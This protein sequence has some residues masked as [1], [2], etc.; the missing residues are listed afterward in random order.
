[1]SVELSTVINPELFKSATDGL[2]GEGSLK[3]NGSTLSWT[4]DPLRAYVGLLSTGTASLSLVADVAQD[5]TSATMWSQTASKNTTVDLVAGQVTINV[6][7]VYALNSWVT[8]SS[9]TLNTL[10]SIKYNV[11]GV[12]SPSSLKG[13]SKDVGDTNNLSATGLV[14][15]N[16][17]DTVKITIESDKNCTATISDCGYSMIKVDEV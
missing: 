5:I 9:D 12:P 15:F 3:Y 8:V 10:F 4:G 16:Q 17:G 13:L 2:S 1:M 6:S 7:G 11:N 14:Q